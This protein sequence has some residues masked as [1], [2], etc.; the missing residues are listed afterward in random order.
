MQ[1]PLIQVPPNFDLELKPSPAF[2]DDDLSSLYSN[3][4]RSL[5]LLQKALASKM[6][7]LESQI[8]DEASNPENYS[9]EAHAQA[10]H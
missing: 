9:Y 8:T 5:D 2:S 6:L 7:T 4:V 10:I 1:A 3:I